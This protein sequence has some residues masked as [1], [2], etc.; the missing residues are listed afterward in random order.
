M[1]IMHHTKEEIKQRTTSVADIFQKYRVTG[2]G[3][4]KKHMWSRK[5][6]D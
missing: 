3:G 4:Y 5:R 1:E 6:F 2:G